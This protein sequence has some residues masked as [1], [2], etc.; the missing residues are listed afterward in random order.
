MPGS[1]GGSDGA[2]SGWDEEILV[3]TASGVVGA[4]GAGRTRGVKRFDRVVSCSLVKCGALIELMDQKVYMD[5]NVRLS[6]ENW[7]RADACN[8]PFCVF[9]PC[10]VM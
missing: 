4:G 10:Q 9:L 3:G 1:G 6:V 5:R 8:L 2:G 7:I